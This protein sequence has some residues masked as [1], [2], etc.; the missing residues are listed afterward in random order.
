VGSRDRGA[1]I[2]AI[3]DRHARLRCRELISEQ[4]IDEYRQAPDG[5]HSDPLARLLRYLRSA[6]IDGKL[7]VVCL[8]PQQFRLCRAAATRGAAPVPEGPVFDSVDEAIE[9][10]FLDRIEEL[11][12][13]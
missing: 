5:P 12:R 3:F 7:A 1:E 11:R 2:A 4:L 6:P 8:A 10:V 9:A 13:S